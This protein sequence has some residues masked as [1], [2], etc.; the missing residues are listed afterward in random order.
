MEA[1]GEDFGTKGYMKLIIN[2]TVA[3]CSCQID[4]V[5]L[6]DLIGIVSWMMKDYDLIG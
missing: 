2:N 4:E 5:R 3:F 6:R 1:H